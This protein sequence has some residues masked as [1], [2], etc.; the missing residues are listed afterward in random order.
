MN[1]TCHS[2]F[3]QTYLYKHTDA[4]EHRHT[5]TQ[6]HRLH[7]HRT[8]R[9]T[10]KIVNRYRHKYRYPS[11]KQ[12]RTNTKTIGT[13]AHCF[14]PTMCNH[15]QLSFNTWCRGQ[16]EACTARKGKDETEGGPCLL[17]SR[18]LL[19]SRNRKKCSFEINVHSDVK[20]VVKW[21]VFRHVTEYNTNK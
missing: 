3:L 12:T 15:I 10:W 18:R 13:S 4:Q 16:T 8:D 6:M 11:I 21:Q 1:S 7:R 20:Q 14:H 5:D 9:Y 17:V 19:Y 2:K